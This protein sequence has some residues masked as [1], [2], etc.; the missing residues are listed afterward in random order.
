MS[1]YYDAFKQKC[2]AVIGTKCVQC[3]SQEDLE[4][5]HVNARDK[6]FAISKVWGYKDRW[7]HILEE[8]KKCQALCK[9]CHKLKSVSDISI[10]RMKNRDL[11]H[12][13]LSQ[14]MRYKC[15]CAECST[16]YKAW[17]KTHRSRRPSGETGSTQR[18]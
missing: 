7:P 11:C 15:R 5:D 16:Y 18:S 14:Y 12:G 8:L 4:I 9:A 17:R 2:F 3:Q 1:K 6:S 13:T 10:K